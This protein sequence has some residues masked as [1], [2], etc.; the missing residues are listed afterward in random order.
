[1]KKILAGLALATIAITGVASAQ[2]S[3]FALQIGARKGV[4]DYRQLQLI[5]L[6][7]MAKGEV[8]LGILLCGTGIGVCIAA[9]KV[10]GAYAASCMD[11]YSAERSVLSNNCNIL[12]PSFRARASS[13]W[14]NLVAN[15]EGCHVSG[16]S[17]SS[18][19]AAARSPCQI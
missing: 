3:P 15:S 8:E 2:D 18:F 9:N 16:T 12:T 10:K 7:Q 13:I 4:M 11:P 6:G 5:T 1:M 17:A 14:A 19:S